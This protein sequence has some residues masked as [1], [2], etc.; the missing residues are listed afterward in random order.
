MSVR[1][2]IDVGRGVVHAAFGSR[3]ADQ[4][5]QELIGRL[6]ADPDFSPEHDQVVDTS[7]VTDLQLSSGAIIRL[8]ETGS[9]SFTGRRAIVAP[10]PAVFGVARMFE[11]HRDSGGDRLRV[12]RSM[13]EAHVWLGL[14][15]AG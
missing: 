2:S 5:V 7:E 8:A 9:S 4:D 14:G 13:T 11:M 6:L 10:S 1:Y 3:L 15:D 12:F